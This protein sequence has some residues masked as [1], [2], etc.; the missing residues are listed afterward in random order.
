MIQPSDFNY[1][2][3]GDVGRRARRTGPWFDPMVW[4]LATATVTWL[5][6]IVRQVP[7]RPVGTEFPDAF[8][9][10]CYSDIPRLYLG[11]GIS[12]G[13]GIYTEVDLEYPVLIGYFMEIS[14]TITR[15]LGGHVSPEASYEQQVAASQIFF[16]VSAVGL[17]VCFLIAVVIHVR[18][19]R[20]SP[21]SPYGGPVRAWDALLIAASPVVMA[22]GLINWD[23]LAVMLT[24]LGFLVWSRNSPFIAGGVLGLAFAAKFYPVLVLV[25]ITLLC[26]R[27]DRNQAIVRVWAGAVFT[28]LVVNLPIMVAAWEGW[29]AFWTMNADRGADLGSIWYVLSLIGLRVPAVSVIAFLCMAGGGIG[30]IWLVLR[31]P[32]RPRLG[33]IALLLMVIF[34]VFNKVYSPQYALWLLPLVVLARPVPRDVAIWTLGEIVYFVAIWGFLQGFIGPGSGYDGFYWAAVLARIGVQ[35][36]FGLRVVDDMLHP[37]ED[38]VRLPLVDDPIG[39]VLAHTPDAGWIALLAHR[40]ALRRSAQAPVEPDASTAWALVDDAGPVPSR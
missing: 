19:G 32:R 6:V 13:A 12:T 33:Q 18:M 5:I 8:M 10:L 4:S 39:G 20:R 9:R 25:A 2:L 26:V 24:S 23:L 15:L 30:V 22:N 29:S 17:F 3:G 40:P 37:W 27:A 14:R 21:T 7:C 11:R 1:R 31:A 35:L 16:Q 38:P 34:L 28:W 36:W